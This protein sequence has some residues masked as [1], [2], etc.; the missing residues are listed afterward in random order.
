MAPVSDVDDP[1]P[2]R[3]RQLGMSF[4]GVFACRG[5]DMDFRR[6]E[7]HAL[8]GEN[9]AGKSTTMKCL[10]GLYVPTEGN[11]EVDGE[12][13]QFRSPRDAERR[14]IALIPQELD[15]FPELSIAENMFL[16]AARPRTRWGGIDHRAMRE[17][18]REALGRLGANF[19]P[20]T[21]VK[22][23][24]AANGKLVEIARALTRD[25]RLLI[26]D[27]PTASLT[28]REVSNL[29]RVIRDLRAR[30]MAVIYISHRLDEVFALCD[31][32]TVLRDGRLIASGPVGDTTPA[33]LV[34]TMVGRPMDTLFSRTFH[35]P[36]PVVLA[37]DGLGRGKA[38]RDVSFSLHGGEILGVSGLIGAGRTEVALALFG[39]APAD[40]GTVRLRGAPLTVT[41]PRDAMMSGIAYLPEERR[42]Q[43]LVLDR[44]IEWN[45]GIGCLGQFS[46]GGLIDGRGARAFAARAT[47]AVGV[48]GGDLAGP[49]SHL[50]GGNQ[51][52]V[53][54]ARTLALD[55]DI[56]ILDEPTRGVDVGAK[57]DI[58]RIIDGLARSGK[59][60][61]MISS[62]LN[63]LMSMCDRIVVMREGSLVGTFDRPFS[64]E[65]LGAAAAGAERLPAE[66][67]A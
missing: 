56:V 60:V 12:S 8:M 44:S 33:R 2:Y 45:V 4:G 62:E 22:H 66:A 3:L 35:P 65:A 46:R 59:A 18:A 21:K 10:A 36:G 1:A 43:G 31:R 20:G 9:G 55:P 27:E 13:V 38:F 52:K 42:A 14:G 40:N 5:V 48:K 30:G 51:Q 63:E 17:A 19:D 53:V 49:V 15:L 28:E 39:V 23:L 34:Q 29:F 16:G 11:V 50:S 7:V 54:L 26:M 67:V 24:S 58:Y 64:A 57:S 47:A 25:A 32:I 61:L 6:G 37:V 41:G